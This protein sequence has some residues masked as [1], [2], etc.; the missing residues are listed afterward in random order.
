[1]KGCSLQSCELTLFVEEHTPEASLTR[2]RCG[3]VSLQRIVISSY[4][5]HTYFL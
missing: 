1:M 4:A 5:Q 2:M 3:S